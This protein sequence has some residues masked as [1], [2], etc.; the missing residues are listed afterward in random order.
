MLRTGLSKIGSSSSHLLPFFTQYSDLILC[1]FFLLGDLE[2]PRLLV[3]ALGS[4]E[5]R[6][7]FTNTFEP[8]VLGNSSRSGLNLREIHVATRLTKCPRKAHLGSGSCRAKKGV[9]AKCA[10]NGPQAATRRYPLQSRIAFKVN[11]TVLY[12]SNP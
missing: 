7:A 12:D 3:Q 11:V 8:P 1:D 6:A 2:I 5:L 4:A 9:F 10:R